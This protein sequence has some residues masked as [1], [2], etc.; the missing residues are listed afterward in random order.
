[1]TSV[2]KVVNSRD[3]CCNVCLK[4][5]VFGGFFGSDRSESRW[6]RILFGCVSSVQ[7]WLVYRLSKKKE[8]R[9]VVLLL[10][11]FLL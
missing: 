10:R 11:F 3:G 8:L 2:Q 1:V 9:L 4:C 6:I 7:R 5:G